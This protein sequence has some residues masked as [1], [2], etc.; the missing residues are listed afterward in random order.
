MNFNFANSSH[1]LGVVGASICLRHFRGPHGASGCL[2]GVS[3]GPEGLR[4]VSGGLRAFCRDLREFQGLHTGL[5][6]VPG[7]FRGSQEGS[8]RL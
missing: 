2:R 8:R 5:R 7:H 3:G 6:I 1:V 4:S